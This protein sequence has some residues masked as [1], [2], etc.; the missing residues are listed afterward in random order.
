MGVEN[1]SS[2]GESILTASFVQ[3]INKIFF[4]DFVKMTAPFLQLYI[5]IVIVC[6]AFITEV[7]TFLLYSLISNENISQRDCLF[8][9]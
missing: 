9:P 8:F 4:H 5:P 2:A 6:T 1:E 7:C 3:K